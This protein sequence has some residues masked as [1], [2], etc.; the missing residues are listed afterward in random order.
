MTFLYN[1]S[2]K[3]RPVIFSKAYARSWNAMLEYDGV[4]HGAKDGYRPAKPWK[5]S[6]ECLCQHNPWLPDTFSELERRVLTCSVTERVVSAR[7]DL[8][9]SEGREAKVDCGC[10]RER[11]KHFPKH[12]IYK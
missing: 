11:A 4:V 2:L 5:N 8:R 6:E 3:G 10:W 7:W 9:V 12:Q 1:V